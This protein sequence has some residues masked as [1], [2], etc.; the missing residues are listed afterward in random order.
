MNLLSL[1]INL[2]NYKNVDGELI[3]LRRITIFKL[4]I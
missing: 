4:I 2:D 1:I 3:K